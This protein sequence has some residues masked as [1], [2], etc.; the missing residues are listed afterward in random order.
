MENWLQRTSVLLGEGAVERLRNAHIAVFGLGGVGSFA[1]EALARCG[2]GKLT[3]VDA[4][5]ISL[6]NI[7]RQL[8]ATQQTVGMPKTQVAA[9]RITEINP[10][11]AVQPI[12]AFYG[13]ENASRFFDEPYDFCI[14]AIDTVSSKISLIKECREREIPIVSCMGTGNKLHAEQLQIGRLSKTHTCPL[15]R[16]MRRELKNRNLGDVTVVWSAEE[17]VRFVADADNGRHAPASISF[18][19]PVAGFLLAEYAVLQ[20]TQDSD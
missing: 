2:V 1:V 9:R 8:F 16:V 20:L 17:P 19:P 18:V 4:D 15:C 10:Q 3:V 7:N 11:C 5:S 13:E 6:T 14:D 12:E